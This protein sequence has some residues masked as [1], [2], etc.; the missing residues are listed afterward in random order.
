MKT[1]AKCAAITSVVML[2]ASGAAWAQGY[3]PNQG[4]S[5]NQGLGPNQ[6]FVQNQNFRGNMGLSPAAAQNELS[7][8]GCT[9]TT[10][11]SRC[12]AGLPMQWKTGRRSM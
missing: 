8:Y 10:I 7:R 11:S 2:T 1:I 6:G 12:G 3:G 5:E 9:D 4:L